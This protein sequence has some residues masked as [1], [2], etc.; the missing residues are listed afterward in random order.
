MQQLTIKINYKV[1]S[2][3]NEEQVWR[4][5]GFIKKN[6]LYSLVLQFNLAIQ[7]CEDFDAQQYW[8]ENFLD[9]FVSAEKKKTKKLYIAQ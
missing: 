9:Q 3:E 8:I 7:L 4:K 2:K 5:S 1:A 6:H